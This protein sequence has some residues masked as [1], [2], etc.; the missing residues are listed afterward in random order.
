MDNPSADSLLL[1]VLGTL[2][3]AQARWYVAH[4][5]I[6]LGYGGVQAMHA[7]TGVSRPTIRKGMRELRAEQNVGSGERERQAGGGRKCLEVADPALTVALEQLM[8]ES[9]AGDPM[10][11]L[12]W[13]HKSTARIAAELTRQGHP[14]SDETVRRRL[15][16]RGYSL[17]GNHKGHEGS[18]PATRDAQFHYLNTHVRQFLAAKAPVLSLDTKKKEQVG[19]FKNPGRTWRPER[20]PRVV[21][22]YDFPSLGDG[23]AIP[24]GAYDLQRN[25]G[26]VNV[27]MTHDT[28]EFAVASLRRWWKLRGRRAYANAPGLLL[29]AD[30]GGS[31]GSRSRGWKF[32]LQQF[33]DE[34]GLPLTVCHYPPRTSKWNKIEPRLFSFIS[35]NWQG[36]PLVSYETV[37]ALIGA[38]RTKTGLRVKAVLD[39][40]VYPT[41]VKI[42]DAAMAQLDVTPHEVHPQWNSTVPPRPPGG[43]K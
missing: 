40:Q 43:K 32:H 4:E 23:T 7:L 10:S 24:Y 14:V 9:T 22:V 35:L 25:R 6:R 33:T 13:T 34:L 28:A 27:G 30:G 8:E 21:N 36:Q 2:N 38:P 17:Q 18:S 39:P 41:G 12:R 15:K 37:V 11:L 16:E 3:E 5:A 20:Y 1:R 26:F 19:E 42:S 29:C 31:N